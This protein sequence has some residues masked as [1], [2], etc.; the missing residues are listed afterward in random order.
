MPQDELAV[1]RR[2]AGKPDTT[3]YVDDGE[4]YAGQPIDE[5]HAPKYANG[6]APAPAHSSLKG[7]DTAKPAKHVEV[8][9][10]ES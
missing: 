7:A 8:R 6:E 9:E 4:G 1:R 2:R 5:L 10:P 3:T